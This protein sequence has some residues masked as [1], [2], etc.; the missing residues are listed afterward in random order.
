MYNIGD[1]IVYPMHGAGVIKN[2]QEMD[3]F[4]KTQM[5]YKVTIAAEGMEILI[6]VDK[7]EEVGL[8]EIPTHQDLEAML[9]VLSQPEDKMTSN[10]SKRYQDN[11]DQMKSGDIIDVAKVT[12][13]LMLLDRRKGLSSGDKK[14]LM[15]AKNFLISEMMLIDGKEKEEACKIIETTVAM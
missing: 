10:W 1:K 3:I 7:A 13:N 14:M 2:I 9:Q 5:Y 15:T 12:R 8:R 11:M 4:E 6:P